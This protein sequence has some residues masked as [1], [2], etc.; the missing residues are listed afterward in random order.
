MTN[1]CH[2]VSGILKMH[3]RTNKLPLL[4]R[5]LGEI[6][7][8]KVTVTT[9]CCIVPRGI[10]ERVRPELILAFQFRLPGARDEASKKRMAEVIDLA[11]AL[12]FDDL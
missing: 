8:D 12:T 5:E 4:T 6:Y 2:W 7:A 9:D 1:F 10:W 11:Q 3:I